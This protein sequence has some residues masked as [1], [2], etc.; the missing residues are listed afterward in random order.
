[1]GKLLDIRPTQKPI[2]LLQLLA[3]DKTVSVHAVKV[4][5]GTEVHLH[6]SVTSALEA[7]KR[8]ASLTG[9]FILGEKEVGTH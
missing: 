2:S 4:Y 5:V 7:R 3:K 8:S 1:L 9:S 6:S